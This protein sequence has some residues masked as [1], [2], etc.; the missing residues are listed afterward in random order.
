MV[1]LASPVAP[2]V[3]LVIPALKDLVRPVSCEHV[4][5]LRRSVVDVLGPNAVAVEGLRPTPRGVVLV[6][7]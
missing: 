7:R 4:L 3:V 6:G 2:Q 1:G 5:E